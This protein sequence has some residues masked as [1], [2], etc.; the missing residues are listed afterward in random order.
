L[1]PLLLRLDPSVGQYGILAGLIVFFLVPVIVLVFGLQAFDGTLSVFTSDYWREM[2]LALGR[3]SCWLLGAA[4]GIATVEA[5][6]WL[7]GLPA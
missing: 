1:K 4:L 7:I 3:V 5:L 6:R 2:K